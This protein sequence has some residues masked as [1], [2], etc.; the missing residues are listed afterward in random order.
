M[1]PKSLTKIS[2]MVSWINEGVSTGKINK[3]MAAVY[4][5]SNTTSKVKIALQLLGKKDKKLQ[6]NL[7]QQA[8]IHQEFNKD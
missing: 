1:D 3:S 2:N 5:G 4:R 8:A 7:L 6:E